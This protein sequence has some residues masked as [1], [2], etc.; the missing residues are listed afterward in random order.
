MMSMVIPSPSLS[1]CFKSFQCFRLAFIFMFM[2]GVSSGHNRR[3]VTFLHLTQRQFSD[4]AATAAVSHHFPLT[5][6]RSQ[7]SYKSFSRGT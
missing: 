2:L 4:R 1:L 3:K 6:K 7:Q 5:G